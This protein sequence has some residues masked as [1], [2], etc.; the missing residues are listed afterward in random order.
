M[1]CIDHSP[2]PCLTQTVIHNYVRSQPGT[3]QIQPTA[4]PGHCRL[5][6]LVRPHP[7]P[8]APLRRCWNPAVTPSCPWVRPGKLSCLLTPTPAVNFDVGVILSSVGCHLPINITYKLYSILFLLAR[9]QARPG[10]NYHE[11]PGLRH[12]PIIA[13]L[14]KQPSASV[15]IGFGTLSRQSAEKTACTL[16]SVHA[17]VF[18]PVV[19]TVVVVLPGHRQKFG[20]S[21]SSFSMNAAHWIHAVVCTS[22]SHVQR[23]ARSTRTTAR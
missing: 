6:V 5:P 10:C 15:R 20:D 18:S 2:F 7:T 19:G 22:I 12:F 4:P 9:V 21:N 11:A 1:I 17:W 8:L 16:T 13:L 23:E 3:G 14:S